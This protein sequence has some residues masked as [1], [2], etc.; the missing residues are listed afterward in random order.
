[1]RSTA[2]GRMFWTVRLRVDRSL[3]AGL[4]P[5]HRPAC[6]RRSVLA[7]AAAS[8]PPVAPSARQS[9]LH[10]AAQPSCSRVLPGCRAGFG[11]LKMLAAPR[12]AAAA[13]A[14]ALAVPGPLEMAGLVALLRALVP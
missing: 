3:R 6:S 4:L 9:P 8:F 1:M 14:L 11:A 2:A 7:G 10:T 12:D 13:E 5:A